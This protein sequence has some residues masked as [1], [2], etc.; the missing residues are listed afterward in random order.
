[1]AAQSLGQQLANPDQ[2]SFNSSIQLS[3]KSSTDSSTH[4]A[5]H[6]SPRAYNDSFI[7]LS[8]H[9]SPL[10][11][12]QSSARDTSASMTPTE[13]ILFPKLPLEL[14]N[15]IWNRAAPTAPILKHRCQRKNKNA[16]NVMLK[17][18]PVEQ[19]AFAA[20]NVNA[21]ARREIKKAI[22]TYK[23]EPELLGD[24]NM[25]P[26]TDS[27]IC[28]WNK[29]KMTLYIE[30]IG[31]LL[32]W[33]ET[34][35]G[36][37]GFPE[38]LCSKSWKGDK[39][40]DLL[41]KA[42]EITGSHYHQLDFNEGLWKNVLINF[43]PDLWNFVVALDPIQPELYF[44]DSESEEE[45]D[46][47]DSEEVKNSKSARKARIAKKKAAHPETYPHGIIDTP[48]VKTMLGDFLY[49]VI[50]EAYDAYSENNDAFDDFRTY[51][52][53]MVHEGDL[54]G[55]LVLEGVP[56]NEPEDRFDILDWLYYGN[57][58][59]DFVLRHNQSED[60]PIVGYRGR[61]HR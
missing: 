58:D 36:N 28:M 18:L 14:R 38:T 45:S 33:M 61:Q 54:E 29:S 32:S 2:V 49:P 26:S 53:V 43:F 15:K 7:D 12:A 60:L 34:N 19:H 40:E 51:P 27:S 31:K 57:F 46:A 22:G 30:N 55:G 4:P 5:T 35:T 23:A 9:T 59:E 10:N 39:V 6:T 47:E 56:E 37:Y 20:V 16:S 25:L 13:F 21:E 44:T 41:V 50:D 24:I 3:I 1:M 11:S 42:K 52:G 48:K 17:F 8:A